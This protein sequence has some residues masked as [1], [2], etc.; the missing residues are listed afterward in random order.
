MIIIIVN[1]SPNKYGYK[2]LFNIG[3][4]IPLQVLKH[5]YK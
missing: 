1:Q 3:F 5:H 4:R 2:M